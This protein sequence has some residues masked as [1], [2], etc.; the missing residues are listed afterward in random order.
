MNALRT[1]LKQFKDGK[2]G[3]RFQKSYF[4]RCRAGHN[5]LHKALVFGGGVLILAGG[6]IM[7][8]APGPGTIVV[9]LGAAIMA[10]ESRITARALDRLELKLR[11][12]YFRI[13]G[14]KRAPR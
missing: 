9:V 12:L 3:E 10:G 8:P 6:V 14:D 5:R 1:A 13:K 7:L 2:P 4:E 11:G